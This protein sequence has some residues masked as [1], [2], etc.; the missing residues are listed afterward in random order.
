MNIIEQSYF[1]REIFDCYFDKNTR[2]PLVISPRSEVDLITWAQRNQRKIAKA[3][4]EFGAIVFSGFNL[5]KENF[6][7]AFTAITG[8]PPQV[9]KGDTPRDEVSFQ[10][11][12]ST[13]VA[14][15]HTIP[16]HQEVSGGCRKDMPKYISFFCVTP[17]EKETGQTVVGNVKQVSEKIQKLIPHLW[18]KMSTKTL[19]YTARYLPKNSWRT[20]WIRWLN[21][22]HATIEKRFGTEKREEV[23]E[24]C[25]Q[26]GLICEWDGEWAAISRKGVPATIDSNGIPLFCNQI[27]LDRF[28]PK[29]CGGWIM[30]IVARILLYPTSRSMQ[31]NVK[32]DDGT[33]I[34]RK[35][36]ST[37]LN[38]IQEYQQGRNWK[39]SDLMILDN[40]TT[41]HGKTSHVGRREILV[42]MSGSVVKN[43]L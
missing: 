19:T 43:S 17:P 9:Y 37:L 13:A 7:E 8:K 24:K 26:E 39:K 14:N 5:T 34:S 31:F 25:R 36:A 41:M 2:S 15:G 29:L 32:F 1:P 10:V 4:K 28:N 22:S 40:A 11:Y 33:E 38:I 12:K 27:H 42:A 23:E 21:P 16:L 35:D 3:I 18:Q 6:S 20:K 30:Y